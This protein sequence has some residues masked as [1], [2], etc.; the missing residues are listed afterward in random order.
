MMN[1]IMISHANLKARVRRPGLE[2]HLRRRHLGRRPREA[3]ADRRSS[4]RGDA[5]GQAAAARRRSS[6]SR[7]TFRGAREGSSDVLGCDESSQRSNEVNE[8][9]RPWGH[10]RV[11]LTRRFQ[12]QPVGQSRRCRDLAL[13]QESFKVFKAF[14][15]PF[16]LML[17]RIQRVFT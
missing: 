2:T 7:G 8:V 14:E 11:A 13:Q 10:G 5:F 3:L 15:R 1:D 9:F 12:L 17:N 4:L 16:K 6:A